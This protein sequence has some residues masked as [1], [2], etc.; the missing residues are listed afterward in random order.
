M[1]KVNVIIEQGADGFF[2]YVA[3][4]DGCT[5]GGFTFSEVKSNILSILQIALKEDRNLD[6]KYAKG[7]DVQFKISLEFVFNQFPELNIE[8]LAKES[9]I[10]QSALKA[11]KDGNRFA[12]EDE[13]DAI[14]VAI[15][16]LGRRFQSVRLTR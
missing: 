4:I 1:K 15:Q 6:I 16:A 11:I 9:G 5:A 12:T 14:N 2:A 3:E 8:G 7:Y 10:K 13:A